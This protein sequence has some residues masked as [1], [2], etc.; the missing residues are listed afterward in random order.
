MTYLQVG[1][2]G[3]TGPVFTQRACSGVASLTNASFSGGSYTM[4]AGFG[5][6]EMIGATYTLQASEFP[7][8]INLAEW[9][10]VQSNT[11]VATTTRWSI[12]FFAGNPSTGTL[13]HTST[14]DDVILP[15]IRMPVGTH[16][17]NVQ[18]SVDPQDPEQ[19]IIADNGSHQFTVAWRI[20]LHN[21]QTQNPC[22]T[23]PPTSSNAFP[24]T[25]NP[26]GGL[27]N[28]T[29]NWLYGL[30]CGP[31]GCPNNGGWAR[32][33]GAA[34]S[35]ASFCRPGG[36]WVTRVTWE[37]VNCVPVVGACCFGNG[38]C[39]VI[40]AAACAAQG[41]TYQGNDVTCAA[42]NCPQPTRACCTAGV[43]SVT[44]QAA[45]VAGGGT[46]QS[47]S[48][49][50]T[51][52]SCPQ[53]TGAC[54]FP[55]G[56][57]LNQTSANCIGAGG[58]WYGAGSACAPNNV[59][60]TGA[61]CLPSGSCVN[62]VSQQ[63]CTAQS[64]T[65]QGIGTN[66]AG[67]NCPQPA[68]ACCFGTFCIS[69]TQFDCN[70]GGGQWRGALTT[71]ADT[72]SNGTADACEPT[73]PACDPIDF[74]QDGLFPDTLDIDD[75]LSVFSGGACSNDPNCGDIDFNN[76]GLFPDTL[77]IDSLLSVFSGAA[78]SQIKI[79]HANPVAHAHKGCCQMHA[80]GGQL[81]PFL[82]N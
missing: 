9:I 20:D 7:V 76:D 75:F 73:G 13:V 81:A 41:G 50:C 6:G 80:G 64:G 19:I 66:C 29:M 39:Q 52:V 62:G 58:T 3:Q 79:Q 47:A 11:N 42:A 74:N 57:C 55:N 54:C 68:G 18:F 60:P 69:L 45:C 71:C 53:P 51:G 56:F 28:P 49:T 63:Q 8:K 22:T 67:V 14:A 72:N 44:T 43:C 48:T 36:D 32:F 12:L 17:T 38:S 65:F 21:N 33:S 25:D 16:G 78:L 5:Q 35:L 31:I 1:P 61:C 4:Q 59:C 30:N 10:V 34:P 15:Y 2:H 37:T 26:S 40:E 82:C 70:G 46:W 27:N 24:C 77:D 23:A